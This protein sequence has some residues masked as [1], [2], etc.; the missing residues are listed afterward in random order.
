MGLV[1]KYKLISTFFLIL[2]SLLE[3]PKFRVTKQTSDRKKIHSLSDH[4]EVNRNGKGIVEINLIITFDFV[5]H[6]FESVDILQQKV[7]VKV[8]MESDKQTRKA[9]KVAVNVPGKMH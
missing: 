4:Q 7:V 2:L 9:M 3:S 5:L 1:Y 8:T 6:L